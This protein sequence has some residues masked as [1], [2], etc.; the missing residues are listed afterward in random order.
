MNQKLSET[1]THPKV[2]YLAVDPSA[3]DVISNY[4]S[5]IEAKARGRNAP[6]ACME[7]LQ[8][9]VDLPFDQGI[10]KEREIFDAAIEST[11]SRAMRYVFF[12]E[13]QVSKVPGINKDTPTRA[14][15]S[16]AVLGAGTMGGGIAMNFANAGIP[17]KLLDQEQPLL[18]KGMAIITKNYAAT[19]KKGRLSQAAMNE[20][21]RL[22]S[23]TL[24]F[25][26]LNEVDM[27]VE[28]VFEEMSLK[29]EIF[30]RLD[31][32]CN[33][34]AIL[35]SN[36]SYLNVN[37]LAAQTSR[38]PN[39][40]GTHFF[41]PANVMR[42]LEIVRADEC[43]GETLASVMGRA[44]RMGKVGVIS[45]VCPGLIGNR[46]LEGYFREA[47]FII[48]EG[49]L[50]H[51]VDK[52]ITDF[53][54]PMGPFAVWDLAG[55]DI[56]WRKRQAEADSRNPNERYSAIGDRLCE[57]GRFGQK[58]QA[59]YYRYEEGSRIP[60]PDPHVEKLI[61]QTSDEAGITRR[62][63][64]EQEIL[65]RCLYPLINEGARILEEEI[66][67]RASDID[68]I[69][70]Y[71][72]GFPNYRGGPMFYADTVGTWTVYDTIRKYEELHG[73]FRQPAD[74]LKQLAKSNSKF[75][76]N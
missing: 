19:V 23:P 42:L 27:V 7:C 73:E 64:S 12:S 41:S 35:A 18:D 52:I 68:I 33:K 38:A 50:P 34:D 43:S 1:S 24:D 51:E 3:A 59:G 9:A 16:A 44:K 46:M 45:G 15:D 72:Y 66:A 47:G 28:A 63:I 13:R 70:L 76:E 8:A 55:L 20:R 22:I 21:L 5:N 75:T 2:R 10:A 49:A 26:S 69:Y 30:K 67:I 58:P 6:L 39:V 25:E 57:M 14:I 4:K 61:F 56:G 71:G 31:S 60:I 62:K 54:F 37:E 74:L 53:G 40:L 48:E 11:E 17:V 36:T 65:T 32:V 29:K